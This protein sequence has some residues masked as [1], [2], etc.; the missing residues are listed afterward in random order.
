MK[1][2]F[3]YILVLAFA[4]FTTSCANNE[5]VAVTIASI[6]TQGSGSWKVAYAKFGDEEA[7]SGMYDGFLIIFK[8]NGTYTVTNPKGAAIAPTS[9]PAGS[10]KEGTR[11]TVIFD[12]TVTVREISRTLSSNKIIFEWEFSI[13]G[14]V[15]TTYRIELVRA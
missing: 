9:L 15:T 14:K 3:L 1:R 4:F 7:P 5:D 10:W 2:S 12:G 13:P 11:N 6:L 8:N